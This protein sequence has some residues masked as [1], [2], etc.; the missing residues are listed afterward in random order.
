MSKR[1]IEEQ[2]HQQALFPSINIKDL[3]TVELS[4]DVAAAKR[5]VEDE[6]LTP[7]KIDMPA[8][9]LKQYVLATQTTD[10]AVR[11]EHIKKAREKAEVCYLAK[12]ARGEIKVKDE[13]AEPMPEEVKA[14]LRELNEKKRTERKLANE[15]K[16]KLVAA[17]DGVKVPK[18]KKKPVFNDPDTQ[19]L[20][21]S[22]YPW[23]KHGSFKQNPHKLGAT[24]VDIEC[25]HCGMSRTTHLSDVFQ[26]RF[27]SSCKN[28][29]NDKLSSRKQ[30]V[31]KQ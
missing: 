5:L 31:G 11:A 26:V 17:A 9:V 20:I 27:C 14:Q 24:D 19:S 2:S 12:W 13:N 22:K 15:A 23:V 1:D 25:Q 6:F 28:E 10:M 3:L 8:Y 21:L 30:E 4:A 16:T 7:H 18:K 29:K